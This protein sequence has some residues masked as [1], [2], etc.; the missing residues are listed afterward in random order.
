LYPF[1]GSGERL[2]WSGGPRR[3][4]SLEREDFGLFLFCLIAFSVFAWYTTRAI[5]EEN[6]LFLFFL[7]PLALAWAVFCLGHP[8]FRA[9]RRKR[10]TYGLTDRRALVVSG[11]GAA[12]VNSVDLPIKSTVTL[13]AHRDGTGTIR[14]GKLPRIIVQKRR[15]D[16]MP[17]VP[18]FERIDGAEQVYA[19]I[20]GA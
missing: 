12:N 13:I 5:D 11:R 10:T 1:L 3:G 7:T 6:Y 20:Q 4:L 15:T 14:L 18:A 9:A 19:M 2:L 16:P 8:F 17:S